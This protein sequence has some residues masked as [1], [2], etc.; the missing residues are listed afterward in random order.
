[1]ICCFP[2]PIATPKN[3]EAELNK[4]KKDLEAIKYTNSIVK[5][6]QRIVYLR[7]LVAHCSKEWW[8]LIRVPV[9]KLLAGWWMV[10]LCVNKEAKL[11]R[12]TIRRT[13]ITIPITREVVAETT[14]ENLAAL[15]FPAP[16]SF[17]TLTLHYIFINKL[18]LYFSERAT[19][20]VPTK[21]DRSLIVCTHLVP[22]RKAM[23]IINSHPLIVI[24][25]TEIIFS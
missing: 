20:E 8:M 11:L 2:V 13:K 21:N 12:K 14:A 9:S 15:P 10:A 16:S 24:L 25:K 23:G 4:T 5:L 22:T 3:T 6:K 17:D 18:I 1:M 7:E 19:N